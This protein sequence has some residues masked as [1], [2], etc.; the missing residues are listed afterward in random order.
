MGERFK[1][2]QVSEFLTKGKQIR[3]L[4]QKTRWTIGSFELLHGT[5]EFVSPHEVRDQKTEEASS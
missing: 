4:S 1:D 3:K 5:T 2:Y